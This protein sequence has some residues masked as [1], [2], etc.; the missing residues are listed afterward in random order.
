MRKLIFCFKDGEILFYE[1]HIAGKDR[2]FLEDLA[3]LHKDKIPAWVIKMPN[4]WNK[5]YCFCGECYEG[6]ARLGSLLESPMSKWPKKAT[7]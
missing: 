4:S 2:W 5:G 3:E 7:K 1:E 6:N